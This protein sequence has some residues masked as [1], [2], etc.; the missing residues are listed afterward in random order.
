MGTS[1][2]QQDCK[3]CK[4]ILPTFK[5]GASQSTWTNQGSPG[6]VE[7]RKQRQ[8]NDLKEP[9]GRKSDEEGCTKTAVVAFL[10]FSLHL[11]GYRWSFLFC[12]MHLYKKMG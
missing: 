10:Q 8:Q 1:Q 4:L 3:R 7:S 9:K 5:Q 6:W 2:G 12:L 11:T